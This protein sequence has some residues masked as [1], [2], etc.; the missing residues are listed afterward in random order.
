MEDRDSRTH[1]KCSKKKSLTTKNSVFCKA[2]FQKWRQSKHCQ[3]NESREFVPG[4]SKL[5]EI[6]TSSSGWK[7]VAPDINSNPHERR[8]L[9]KVIM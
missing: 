9:V 8:V 6:L 1:S 3:I 2:I 4:R 7:Q 5:Q